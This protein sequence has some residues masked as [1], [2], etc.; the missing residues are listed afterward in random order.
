MK[1]K[2]K[3]LGLIIILLVITGCNNTNKDNDSI[4][5]GSVIDTNNEKNNID[6]E[7]AKNNEENNLEDRIVVDLRKD[8]YLLKNEESR[9]INGRIVYVKEIN[10]NSVVLEID[11]EE[12]RLPLNQ[13]RTIKGIDVDLRIIEII[14]EDNFILEFKKSQIVGKKYRYIL[15]VKDK[16]NFDGRIISVELRGNDKAVLDVDGKKGTFTLDNSKDLNGLEIEVYEIVNEAGIDYDYIY[17]LVKNSE[18]IDRNND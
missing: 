7:E 18:E 17:M 12:L 4:T 8:E 2:I 15:N 9:N 6:N 13:L 16:V 10:D 11:G 14:D 1:I 5:G 3:Y